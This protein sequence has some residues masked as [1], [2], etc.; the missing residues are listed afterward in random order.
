MP[1]RSGVWGAAAPPLVHFG[2]GGPFEFARITDEQAIVIQG[3]QWT[4]RPSPARDHS[5]SLQPGVTTGRRHLP[6]YSSSERTPSPGS[7]DSSGLTH[8]DIGI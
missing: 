3:D 5:V 7:T 1:G 4:A 2:A 8:A 6:D